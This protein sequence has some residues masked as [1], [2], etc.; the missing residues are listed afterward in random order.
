MPIKLTIKQERFVQNLLVGMS[1]REAYKNSY[2]AK[3]MSDKTIDSKASLLFSQDKV[4]ARYDE[5]VEEL[6]DEAIMSAKERLKWLSDLVNNK[7]VE[8]I[9]KI[10]N[11]KP[12]EVEIHADFDQKIRAI[13]T[14]NK[15]TGEYTSKVEAE[16]KVKKLE[17]LL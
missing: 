5:L 17:D 7:E 13:D 8:R 16:M 14:M 6:Q 3:K 4:R 11:G 1:Q 12:V 10:I 15:M 2:N 9:T